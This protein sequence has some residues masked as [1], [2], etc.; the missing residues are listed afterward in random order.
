ML[1]DIKLGLTWALIVA[2][3][4]GKTITP[5]WL[6]AGVVFALLPDID[7]WLEYIKRGTVGGKVIDLHRTLLHAPITYIP[8]ALFVGTYFGP[9]WMSLLA[10]GVLGHF[11]HDSM[12]MSYGIRWLWPFS[13]RWYKLF[14]SRDGEI[15]YDLDYVITSWS[16]EEMETLVRERGNDNWIQ[17]ELSYMRRHWLSITLKLTLTLVVVALLIILLPL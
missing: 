12:G 10:L 6:I 5:E 17:E 2:V 11:I 13:T 3:L 16:A 1:L 15:H 8:I 9:A 7:F 4:F 14:S